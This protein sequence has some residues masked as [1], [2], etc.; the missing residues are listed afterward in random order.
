[1]LRTISTSFKIYLTDLNH[2]E[3]ERKRK[4]CEGN[5]GCGICVRVCP[6]NTVTSCRFSSTKRKVDVASHPPPFLNSGL[7]WLSVLD[8]LWTMR[9]GLYNWE[10]MAV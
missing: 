7:R 1:M 10:L 4:E 5:N 6:V 9:Y 2:P 3:M 8:L